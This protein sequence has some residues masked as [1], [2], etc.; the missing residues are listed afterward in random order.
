MDRSY[1]LFPIRVIDT[2]LSFAETKS[3]TTHDRLNFADFP[4][5]DQ[6]HP[7]RQDRFDAAIELLNVS[8]SVHGNK[9][10]AHRRRLVGQQGNL[11][12]RVRIFDPDS[13]CRYALHGQS[14]QF[15]SYPL[16]RIPV[17]QR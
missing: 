15:P 6:M 7:P 5:L 16:N 12:N 2:R 3:L 10:A 9:L 17:P 8:I 1:V 4:H 14:F 11:I 13:D